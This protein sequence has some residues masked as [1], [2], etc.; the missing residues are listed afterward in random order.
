MNSQMQ[1]PERLTYSVTEAA[2]AI[3]I[4][5]RPIYELLRSRQLASVKFGSRRLIRSAELTRFL[6]EL[7]NV[8]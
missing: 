3:R 2:E 1:R 4:S 8:A 5:R 6:A 7:E